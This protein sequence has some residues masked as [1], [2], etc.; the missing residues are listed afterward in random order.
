MHLPGLS[1]PRMG[2]LKAVFWSAWSLIFYTYVLFPLVLAA[3]ARMR[4]SVKDRP[5]VEAELPRVAMVV[6]AFDE[7]ASLPAKLGNTWNLDYPADR[8]ELLIGSD[9]SGDGTAALLQHCSDPRLRA[10]CFEKRR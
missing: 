1:E 9:G 7:E 5:T 8:F 4:A 6:A 3:M 2:I 10:F